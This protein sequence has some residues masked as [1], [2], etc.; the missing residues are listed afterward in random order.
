MCAGQSPLTD[1]RGSG[2]AGALTPQQTQL[3]LQR[4]WRLT[5]CCAVLYAVQTADSRVVKSSKA[6]RMVIWLL[7]VAASQSPVLMLGT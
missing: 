1:T 7:H 6:G 5:L 3:Q 2:E 4:E